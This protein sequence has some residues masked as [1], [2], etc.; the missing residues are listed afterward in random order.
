MNSQTVLYILKRVALALL[1]TWIVITITFFAM[2]AIPGGPFLGEKAV[3]DS[4]LEIL[5]AK[6]GLDK[7]LF[8]QYLNYLKN[9]LRFDFGPSIKL[10]GQFVSELVW[11]RFQVSMK[12]GLV[13]AFMAIIFGIVLGS[14]AAVFHNKWIDK[15]IMVMST[16]A[17]ALPSFVTATVLLFIFCGENGILPIGGDTWQGL[18]L[19]TVALSL[20]PTSYI[21]RLTRSSTLDVMSQDYIRTARAKGV[22]FAGVLFKHSLRNALTPVITYAGPMIAYIVT[23]SLVVEK[24]FGVP[25]LGS[26]FVSCITNRDYTVIMGTTIFLTVLVIFLILI[27]DILYKIINP[28]ISFE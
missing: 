13:A 12:I 3:T 6:Y 15:A 18:I 10:R 28:R 17:V 14:F 26:L 9:V 16:A 19:P 27:G 20:Y 8:I 2:H 4:V 25:G 7:P 24:I 23:G 1:T 22:S 11:S 21:T 5:E